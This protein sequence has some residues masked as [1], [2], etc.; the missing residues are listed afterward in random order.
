MIRLIRRDAPNWPSETSL[1]LLD[2]W[3]EKFPRFQRWRED[4]TSYPLDHWERE[5]SQHRR[6]RNAEDAPR[7]KELRDHYRTHLAQIRE[8]TAPPHVMSELAQVHEGRIIEGRGN[9][10][11]E[12][13]S[14]FFEGDE[15]RR[16][17]RFL[18]ARRG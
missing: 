11:E 15:L 10:P 8:G 3:V 4:A 9:T 13:L 2:L 18:R 1:D 17:Q 14:D 6:K 5:Q 16:I 7:K 12:R